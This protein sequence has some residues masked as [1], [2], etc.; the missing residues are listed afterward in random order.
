MIAQCP[1]TASW[2]F[3][4]WT[5]DSDVPD[6]PL[7]TLLGWQHLRMSFPIPVPKKSIGPVRWNDID[8]R[9]WRA[10]RYFV[11]LYVSDE[12]GNA[13]L[14]PTTFASKQTNPFLVTV[15]SGK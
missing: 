2:P 3:W 13:G 6:M 5:K 14:A 11:G 15:V 9:Q 7:E 8:P 1:D 10:G 12:F 4:T